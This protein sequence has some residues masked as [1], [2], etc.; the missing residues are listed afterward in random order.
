MGAVAIGV[1][2]IVAGS[3]ATGERR[4][5]VAF[6]QARTGILCRV[7]SGRSG[8]VCDVVDTEFHECICDHFGYHRQV[9]AGGGAVVD[10][11]SVLRVDVAE[12]G[13]KI[14]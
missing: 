7:C 14:C 3:V 13:L 1:G 11:D 5:G 10:R 8:V 9:A 2:R 6:A 4:R 12:G